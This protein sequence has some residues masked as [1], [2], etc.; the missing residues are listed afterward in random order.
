MV[1]IVDSIEVRGGASAEKT[2]S[3]AQGECGARGKIE[4]DR[5]L[6][7]RAYESAGF[8]KR[9]LCLP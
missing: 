8:R 3:S 2:N 4:D 7:L 9:D 6:F 5:V 1:K